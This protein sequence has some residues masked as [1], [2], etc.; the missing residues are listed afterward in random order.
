MKEQILKLRNEGKSYDE[1]V[2]ILGCSKGTISYHCGVNQKEKTKIRAHNN[3]KV[4]F[5]YITRRIRSFQARSDDNKMCNKSFIVNPFTTEQFLEKFTESTYC[6]LT[7]KSINLRIDRNWCLD[8]KIPKSK[9]GDN[10][11][12]NCQILLTDINWM[13]Q[14]MLEEELIQ[15]CKDI[16]IYKGFKIE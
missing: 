10:S 14:A 3:R 7:G 12:E 11:L 5:A 15:N 1:I 4:F 2:K 9:G 8:H 6:A 16:L 13:K